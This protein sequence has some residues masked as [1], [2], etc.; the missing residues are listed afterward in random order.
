MGMSSL[1][2]LAIAGVVAIAMEID[3]ISTNTHSLWIM[4]GERTVGG[5]LLQT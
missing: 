5:L 1:F 3:V 4:Y 2:E